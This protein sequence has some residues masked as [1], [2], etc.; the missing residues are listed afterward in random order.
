MAIE[1]KEKQHLRYIPLMLVRELVR[2]KDVP[3]GL[4]KNTLERIIKKVDDIPTFMSIY[5]RD[6]SGEPI[7]AAV[8]KALA[9][10]IVKFSAHELIE[11][12]SNGSSWRLSDVVFMVH[13]KPK[14]MEQAKV[15]ARLLSAR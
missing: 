12:E 11:Y 3:K 5:R 9:E 4:V 14:N 7:A 13:P 15:F 2:M 6:N 1:A 10:A 8:K